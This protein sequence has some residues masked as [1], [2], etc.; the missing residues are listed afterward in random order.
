MLN[1][2]LNSVSSDFPIEVRNSLITSTFANQ[3]PGGP[4][5]VE[6]YFKMNIRESIELLQELKSQELDSLKVIRPNCLE[7]TDQLLFEMSQNRMSPIEEF[8]AE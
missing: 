6:R 8:F 2:V 5:S 1:H 4:L 3:F 7:G